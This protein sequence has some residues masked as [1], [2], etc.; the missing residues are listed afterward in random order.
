[1]PHRDAVGDRDGSEFQWIAAGGVDAL[2][3]RR[4]QPLQRQVAR[5]DFVPARC[6]G[7]LRLGEVLVAHTD[8]TQHAT[9]RSP[10]E[11]IGYLATAG[12]DV[13]HN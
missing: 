8:R 4:R 13:W 5:R 7:H 6:D 2:L 12:F 3:G 10:F 11:P 9:G 1:M